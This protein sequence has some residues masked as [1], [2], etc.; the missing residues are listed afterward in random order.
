MKTEND[1]AIKD[2]QKSLEK[3]FAEKIKKAEKDVKA[4]E[5]D[6]LKS[7]NKLLV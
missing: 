5:D 6:K 7:V 1:K 2:L 3:A 4:A